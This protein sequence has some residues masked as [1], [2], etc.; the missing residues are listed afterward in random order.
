M[1]AKIVHAGNAT[2][3]FATSSTDDAG[4]NA[5]K[6]ALS[7]D[8]PAEKLPGA[9]TPSSSERTWWVKKDGDSGFV[10]VLS[11]PKDVDD[12]AKDIAKELSSLQKVDRSNITLHVASDKKGKVLGKALDSTENIEEALRGRTGKIYIVAKVASSAGPATPG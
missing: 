12:L 10:K 6:S 7:V 3:S 4:N 5:D 9:N 1:S 11:I 2:R 8:L